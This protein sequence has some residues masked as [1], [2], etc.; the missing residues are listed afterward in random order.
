MG[1]IIISKDDRNYQMKTMSSSIT[2]VTNKEKPP[3]IG[4]KY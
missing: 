1:F 4:E 2:G 3:E